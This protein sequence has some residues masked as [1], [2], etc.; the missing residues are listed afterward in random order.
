MKFQF[1]FRDAGTIKTFPFFRILKK[2]MNFSCREKRQNNFPMNFK[3]SLK[4]IKNGNGER[5]P[6]IRRGF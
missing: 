6:V 5:N 2:S 3:T 4:N 1:S